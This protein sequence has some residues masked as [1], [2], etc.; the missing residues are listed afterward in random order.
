MPRSTATIKRS[1]DKGWG[2][3]YFVSDNENL[4]S[5]QGKDWVL[6][7]NDDC[8]GHPEGVIPDGTEIT[9]EFTA[10]D[11]KKGTAYY[12]S[13]IEIGAQKAAPPQ[14]R[15]TAPGAQMDEQERLFVSNVLASCAAH[16]N[17]PAEVEFWAVG[18]QK[19]WRAITTPERPG[20]APQ[21][22]SDLPEERF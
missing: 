2:P 7:I 16:F 22:D 15:Q 13:E 14:A 11:S 17:T 12:V 18:C 4:H 1:L 20:D 6:F 8:P 19:A 9:F 3:F 10:K 5:A 21:R